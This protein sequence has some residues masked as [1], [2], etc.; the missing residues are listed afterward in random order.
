MLRST[1][2]HSDVFKPTCFYSDQ[3]SYFLQL[4]SFPELLSPLLPDSL[5]FPSSNEKNKLESGHLS[6]VFQSNNLCWSWWS[7]YVFQR[8]YIC[9]KK[10]TSLAI[11]I[12][13]IFRVRFDP[14]CVVKINSKSVPEFLLVLGA[15]CKVLSIQNW[16]TG[17]T[18]YR[19]DSHQDRNFRVKC[20]HRYRDSMWGYL[21]R[22]DRQHP[23]SAGGAS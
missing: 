5:V 21:H 17:V 6:E 2:D 16:I 11:L 23:D 4:D 22:E 10:K 9:K 15:L 12:S 18:V 7:T 20:R 14:C 8:C 13:I 3:F 1:Y 19:R